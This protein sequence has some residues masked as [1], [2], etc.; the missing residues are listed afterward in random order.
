MKF[1][2]SWIAITLIVTINLSIASCSKEPKNTSDSDSL[3]SNEI[4]STGVENS[5]SENSYV[6]DSTESNL[7]NDSSFSNT[8]SSIE[9]QTNNSNIVSNSTTSISA[10]NYGKYP[11]IKITVIGKGLGDNWL[12][13]VAEDYTHETGN[14]VKIYPSDPNLISTLTEKM[15]G[16]SAMDDIYFTWNSDWYKWAVK[17]KMADL[18]S[19]FSDVN[20]STGKSLN[21]SFVDPE[22]KQFGVY[23]NARYCTPLI[24]PPTGLVYNK[25]YLTQLG[26]TTF[27]DTWEG[28]L[29]LCQKIN[30]STLS[31][32]G[33]KVKPFSWGSTVND[34]DYMF[35]ALWY[36]SD[37]ASF[38]SYWSY[39]STSLI[40]QSN[41]VNSSTVKA[42]ESI[43]DLLAP[44]T[45]ASGVGYSS[46]SV[47]GVVEK[48]NL[49]A[50]E[51]FINGYAVFCET[52]SW[53]KN[54]MSSLLKSSNLSYGFAPFP[55]ISGASKT[56]TVINVPG[57]YFFVPA[58]AK[59]ILGAKSFLKYIY[60][61][62]N[63]IKIQKNI[64]IPVCFNYYTTEGKT[65]LNNL[66]GWAKDCYSIIS[67]SD[68]VLALS[69]SNVF[70]S[71]ALFAFIGDENVYKLMAENKVTRA[72]ISSRIIQTKYNSISSKW[73]SYMDSIN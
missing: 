46:N 52:G 70:M 67:G 20:P 5:S 33:T 27:P 15:S 10:I 35:K 65:Y 59:N 28:L 1:M 64:E 16:N 3:N 71:G 22:L 12:R 34:L 73:K 23:K 24:Y 39:N 31:R 58:N 9:N 57:E 54:E 47:I 60:Q 14:P 13:E 50:Q 29:A 40:P 41:F 62:K 66:T 6:N 37:P 63:L 26:Y 25:A 68:H 44:V 38:K 42:M 17:G 21:E 43:Y 49:M 18:S 45:N 61:E 8:S 69:D 53:F 32:A 2:K 19:V 55:K 30:D 72:N 51:S 36:Q 48:D 4:I 11:E 56:S 7:S